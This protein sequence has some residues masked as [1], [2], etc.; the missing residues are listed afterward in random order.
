MPKKMKQI[1]DTQTKNSL[2]TITIFIGIP[3]LMLCIIAPPFFLIGDKNMQPLHRYLWIS[4]IAAVI[5]YFLI[6]QKAK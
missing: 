5:I 3:L 6:K 1:S 2:Y 4:L